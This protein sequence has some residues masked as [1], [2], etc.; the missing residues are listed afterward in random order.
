TSNLS[1]FN[2]LT[3]YLENQNYSYELSSSLSEKTTAQLEEEDHLLATQVDEYNEQ[4][5]EMQAQVSDLSAQINHME[6]DTT[7]AN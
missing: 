3:K 7:L 4:Y 5:L 1:R 2:D 6:T